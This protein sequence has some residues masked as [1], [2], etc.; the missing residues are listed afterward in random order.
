VIAGIALGSMMQT[1]SATC[2]AINGVWHF[3]AIEVGKSAANGSVIRCVA[4]VATN[5]NFSAP[6][7]I[8]FV[9]VGT[10]MSKNVS[11]KLIKTAACDLTGSITISGD[12][13]V[14]IRFGHLNGNVGSGIATQGTGTNLRVLHFNLTKK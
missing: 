8:Y 10:P 9:G 12:A 1:A 3:H 13:P 2:A 6:C 4:T 11:G 5:G 14:T 7:T